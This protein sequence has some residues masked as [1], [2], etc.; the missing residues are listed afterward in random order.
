MKRVAFLSF[1]WDH[2]I[3]SAYYEGMQSCVEERDD[4]AL[5]IFSAYGEHEGPEAGEWALDLFALCD[6]SRFDGFL[7]QGNRTWPPEQRQRFV[8]GIRALG[9]PVVSLSYELQGVYSVGTDNYQSEYDLVTRVLVDEGCRRPV[10]INGLASSKEAQERKRG[11]LEAC[12]NCGVEP[13]GIYGGSS[14]EGP[15]GAEITLELLQSDQE[16]PDVIFCCNDDLAV[17]VQETLQQYG[18]RVPDQVRVTGFDNRAKARNATPRIATV[19][20]DYR[21]MGCIAFETLMG[22]MDGREYPQRVLSPARLILSESAGYPYDPY[23][24][25]GLAADLYSTENELYDF[26]KVLARFQPAMLDAETL[27]NIMEQC[28]HFLPTARCKNVYLSLNDDFR[29]S[30]L[31]TEHLPYGDTMSFVAYAGNDDVG[32]CDEW[33]VYARFPA[34]ALL[35]PQVELLPTTYMVLPIRHEAACIGVVVTQGLSPIYRYGFLTIILTLMSVFIES[36]HKREVLERANLRLD[37][38][39]VQD[40]LTGLF[41]RF[42]L[43]RYGTIAYEHL[44]RDFDEAQFIFVD[45]DDMKLINDRCGHEA[46]DQSIRDTAEVITCASRGENVFAM[47]YGGDEFLLICRRNLIPRL[48][49]ELAAL[50]RRYDRPYDLELSMGA[51]LVTEDERLTLDE[52]IERA[53]ACMYEVKKARKTARARQ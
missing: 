35:P 9:K 40:Q 1:D 45:I 34:H 47:R 49:E 7:V 46:G 36:T 10:F 19:D 11:F 23:L 50:K 29:K 15:E 8:D 37:E 14:W 32:V 13:V 27:P 48:E 2:V 38:L 41:N 44:L 33:H 43:H 17:G 3:M 53:D 18:V 12:A 26:L 21:G 52:A 28:E 16:L 25:R 42:G 5:F 51:S 4:T 30:D 20:R 24:A 31:E 22:I 39:Y 6:P